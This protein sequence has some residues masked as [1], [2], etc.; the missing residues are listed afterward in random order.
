MTSPVEFEEEVNIPPVL[1]DSTESPLGGLYEFDRLIARELRLDVRVRDE[2]VDD[3]VHLRAR[4]SVEPST[5]GYTEV[6]P[7]IYIPPSNEPERAAGTLTLTE[8]QIQRGACNLVEIFVS[9]QF[10][11]DCEEDNYSLPA[12]RDDL[13][14]GRFWVLDLTGDPYLN[15]M[16][17]QALLNSCQTEQAMS[18]TTPPATMMVPIP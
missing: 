16:R 5:M 13:A 17:A 1:L 18:N 11:Q 7:E 10:Y 8:S 14:S 4:V 6:C 2:N 3:E 15:P 9:S 12:D